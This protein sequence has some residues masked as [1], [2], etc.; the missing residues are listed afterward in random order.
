MSMTSTGSS[1]EERRVVAKAPSLVPLAVSPQGACDLLGLSVSGVYQ[2][3]R[4]GELPS[5]RCG[6]SRRIPMTAVHAF[7]ARRL[8]EHAGKWQPRP[9][10]KS[11][12]NMK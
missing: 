4:S 3:M 9:C 10:P 2:V 11:K 8:A 1:R 12:S 5:Y 7:I 6:R